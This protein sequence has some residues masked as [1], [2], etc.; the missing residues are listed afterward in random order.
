MAV[1]AIAA[2]FCLIE[3]GT[4]VKPVTI[5]PSDGNCEDDDDDEEKPPESL[6]YGTLIIIVLGALAD[7]VGSAGLVR[8]YSS[9][10]MW[11]L[12]PRI[13]MSP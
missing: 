9:N 5:S 3:P 10:E 13:I 12:A 1:S 11:R 8:K 4:I 6:N 2:T 7:N